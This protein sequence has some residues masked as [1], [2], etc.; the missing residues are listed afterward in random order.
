MKSF[1]YKIL[2]PLAF[3]LFSY[4]ISAAR[5]LPAGAYITSAK[6]HVIDNRPEEAV[7]MLDSLFFFYGPHSQ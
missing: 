6:I 3:L 5:K 1:S 7:A 2:I 4:S